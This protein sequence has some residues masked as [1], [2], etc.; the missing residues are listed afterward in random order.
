MNMFLFS[1]KEDLNRNNYLINIFEKKR[2]FNNKSF[3]LMD[4]LSKKYLFQH[5]LGPRFDDLK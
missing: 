4:C 2:T 3:E 1:L 5:A